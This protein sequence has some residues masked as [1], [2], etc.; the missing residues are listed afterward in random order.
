MLVAA[1]GWM[2]KDLACMVWSGSLALC[3]QSVSAVCMFLQAIL[4]MDSLR[5]MH[6]R[7]YCRSR[8]CLLVLML[9]F[10]GDCDT[11]Y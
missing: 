5:L 7:M 11:S 6:P 3:W 8:C 10:P 1:I 9:V 4:R 2:S